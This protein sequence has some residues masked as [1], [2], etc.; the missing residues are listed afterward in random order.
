MISLEPSIPANFKI[1]EASTDFAILSWNEP[2]LPNGQL[3]NYIF[4]YFY[5][6]NGTFRHEVIHIDELIKKV[7]ILDSQK[8]YQFEI[9]AVTGAG[10]G[11]SAK[12]IF[13]FSKCK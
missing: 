5:L 3:K 2:L 8:T 7:E 12:I 9:A 4:W 11:D 1:Q 6:P 13:D 10:M